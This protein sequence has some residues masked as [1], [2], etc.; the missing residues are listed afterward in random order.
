MW[1]CK[2]W[3]IDEK[4]IT[5]IVLLQKTLGDQMKL[6]APDNR[7]SLGQP[8]HLFICVNQ[9]GRILIRASAVSLLII[10]IQYLSRAYKMKSRS[11]IDY[12]FEKS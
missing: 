6:P 11:I 7:C 9:K 1:I 4:A 8:Q 10:A 5:P 2:S 12:K 3:R